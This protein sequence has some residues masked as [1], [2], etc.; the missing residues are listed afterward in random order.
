MRLCLLLL[1]LVG[2]SAEARWAT[3]KDV[4]SVLQEYDLNFDVEKDGSSTME[5][6]QIWRIQTE[7]GKINSSLREIE[8]SAV[9]DKVE[10]LE[11]KT[12]NGKT[13][14]PVASSAIEDRDRGE[15]RDYDGTKVKSLAFPQVQ[16]GSVL[17]LKYRV[18]SSP[19]PIPNQFSLRFVDPTGT[20]M[21][22]SKIHVHSVKPIVFHLYDPLKNYSISGGRHDVTMRLRHMTPGQVVGEKDAYFHPSRFTTLVVSTEADWGKHFA[23]MIDEY[24]KILREKI[25]DSLASEVKSWKKI[26]EPAAQLMHVMEFL[27]RQFR[28]F[29]DWRRVRGGFV[30]RHLAEIDKSRYGDC[31]DLSTLLTRILRELGYKANVSLVDRG[32]TPWMDKPVEKIANVGAFN[33]AITRAEK[34]GHVWWL[35]ATNAVVSLTPYA[36]IA[37]KQ[38]FVIR[39]Q[40][41]GFEKI[42]AVTPEQYQYEEVENY[43]FLGDHDVKVNVQADYRAMG[44]FRL[45]YGFLTNPRDK[46]LFDIVDYFSDGQELKDF[47]YVRTSLPPEAMRE[48][49]DLHFDF[50]YWTPSATYNASLGQFFPLK[51]GALSGGFYETAKRE[52]DL[53][54][55]ETPMIHH[56]KKILKNV[57][58]LGEPTNC[59]IHSPWLDLKRQI[60]F[61]KT[62]IQVLQQA[63]VKV[64]V[65]LKKD[66]TSPAFLKLRKQ[67]RKCF[68]RTGL[69]FKTL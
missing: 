26:K 63:T 54:L 44:G 34:D 32:V 56:S 4:G 43:N 50:T 22:K 28:Y 31:K 19:P 38:T 46:M 30:P 37:G 10:V 7:E 40:N 58:G 68:Y 67:A 1:A 55:A 51:D 18:R 3:P 25:P 11:A 39:S 69:L 8:Y 13:E 17:V 29:G 41:P 48:L 57:K 45:A 2:F 6:T 24:E 65:I 15:S 5:C 62:D 60:I 52:S 27:S 66:Y 49:K 14:T 12:I 20:L 35:D 9:T 23:P 21:E 47:K 61:D 64:P 59:E 53:S 33:H 42:P 36:D 16:V